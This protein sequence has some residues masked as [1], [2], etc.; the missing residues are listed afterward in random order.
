M[1]KN[2]IVNAASG[3]L[4]VIAIVG[5]GLKGNTDIQTNNKEGC[6][7]WDNFANKIGTL[8]CADA[9]PVTDKNAI[10]VN[11]GDVP[12]NLKPDGLRYNEVSNDVAN[13]IK[14]MIP[15]TQ[16]TEIVSIKKLADVLKDAGFQDHFDTEKY[17]DK[18][19]SIP[20]YER[21]ILDSRGKVS[22]IGTYNDLSEIKSL[23]GIDKDSKF[24][25]YGT[26]NGRIDKSKI[27]QGTV[28]VLTYKLYKSN[29]NYSAII[30]IPDINDKTKKVP[31]MMYAH[32]G[33][34]GISFRNIATILQDNLSKAIVAAPSFPGE[35]I[36]S[37]TTIGGNAKNNYQRS[38]GN[39]LGNKIDP[40]V[41]AEG[42]RS[43]IDDDVNALLGLHNAISSLSQNNIKVTGK[44]EATFIPNLKNLLGFYSDIDLINSI[45]GPQTIGA[46]DS[47]G[48]ATLMA[49][50]GRTGFILKGVFEKLN[51]N[52]GF[53]LSILMNMPKPALFSSAAL[54]YSPSS[55][56]VGSFKVLTQYMMNGNINETS[57]Y[58][59]LPM[60]PDLKNNSYF[61][62]YRNA[63]IG[64][65]Q[66]QL[67]ELVGWMAASDI[68][69]LA[70]FM[71]VGMQNWGANLDFLG[72]AANPE[73]GK[74]LAAIGSMQ[75]DPR[76]DNIKISSTLGSLFIEL[77]KPISANDP[78]S[79]LN[80]FAERLSKGKD[81]ELLSLLLGKNDELTTKEIIKF[82]NVLGDQKFG[83]KSIANG[84]I[85]NSN[86]V[87]G[88]DLYVKSLLKIFSASERLKKTTGFNL[89]DADSLGNLFVYFG[90]T[91]GLISAD[92][93]EEPLN[94]IKIR[95]DNIINKLIE[96]VIYQK[97]ISELDFSFLT[98][99][100]KPLFKKT[101]AE[102]KSSPGSIIFLH[103]TQDAVVP[104]MQSVIAKNAMDSVFDAVYGTPVPGFDNPLI[105]NRIPAL[106]SQLFTFQ[107]DQ[108]FYNVAVD[109][110]A[111]L[112]K[113]TDGTIPLNYSPS[114]NKCFGNNPFAGNG[115]GTLAHGDSAIGT[116][117]L[118]NGSLQKFNYNDNKAIV[119]NLL[120]YGEANLP[121]SFP[122][123][124][125]INNQF[126]LFNLAY[127][128]ARS[129]DNYYKVDLDCKSLGT[130]KTG[131]CY[132]ANSSSSSSSPLFNRTIL[133]DAP[134]KASMFD[135]GWDATAQNS[136]M[137][138]ADIFSAWMDSS[139]Q[140]SLNIN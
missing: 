44:N 102:R 31:L 128:K 91:S 11:L 56:L 132:L 111:C 119:Q 26:T 19:D 109:G 4:S 2:R 68:I 100:I 114:L 57:S 106:G 85:G 54:Y 13:Y 8:T 101:M 33:D 95:A 108:K 41:I 133:L 16:A 51:S 74:L 139:V 69:Y 38:C 66:E 125:R 123:S 23:S 120:L 15:K 72:E 124:F 40:A 131:V 10:K 103:A 59:A 63:P 61:T 134:Q 138:P 25:I 5:C 50:I 37:I 28:Y 34:A 73:V 88:Q 122:S 39:A 89:F 112:S 52:E 98:K 107:P 137:T 84:L 81:L 43:P 27:A 97:N 75:L 79:I 29:Q 127:K 104:F 86:N 90:F 83:L 7:K 46:A 24:K 126:A 140:K 3:I 118:V 71:S 70:P 77:S 45:T 105:I 129:I 32:G 117:H 82:L 99:E 30:S 42:D 64:Q 18:I 135:G 6:I 92:L 35:A 115:D 110:K 55:L 49:A 113:N 17:K 65:D 94:Q 9:A 47:R 53:D 21:D 36:C 12:K 121:S 20:F 80:Y 96:I 14:Q 60:V 62:N 67:N 87:N 22:A 76:D 1:K 130:I 78:K 93:S 116:S 58:N 48:G 136:K